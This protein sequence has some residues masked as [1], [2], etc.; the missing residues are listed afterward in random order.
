[1]ATASDTVALGPSWTRRTVCTFKGQSDTHINTGEDYDTCTLAELFTM[2]PG[3]APKGAGPAFIPSTYADYDARNH[4]AQREHGRFV[5]LCGDIDHGDHPLTRV[6]ELVRGFT[7]GAAWL[8]YS[9]AHARPGDMRWRVIIPLDTPLGFADWYDAQHAFFS[10]ME[11]AGVSM[12]KALSRAGQ[13]VYLPNV[14]ETYAKTGEPLRDDFDPLYYQRATSGLNAPGLRIDTGAVCTGMEALRRKRADDD[15]AR[16]E[17]RRQ[18][19]A[20]RARAPQTD[21]API[22]ADFNSANHI[23]TLL[24]LYGYTQCTHSPEDWRSP[25]QTGDTYATRIIGGKWVS[26]SAS[27]TASGMGEKHAAGC[28]GDAYDLFVHYEHGGDHK[29]A[30]RALYKERRNAQ[31]QPDRHT[32][33]GAEDEPEIDPESGQAFTDPPVGEHS[34]DNAP[35]DTL[36]IVHPADWHGETPPDRKWRLQDFIPDLQATLLTGAGAAGKSLTTQQLA[37]CIALGLPFLG[38]PTTQSPALYITCEDDY[39]ELHRRQKA[40]CEALG[41]DLE[42]TRDKLFL[43]SLQGEIG[44]ELATFSH[45]GE[46]KE[47]K[48]YGEILRTCLAHGIKHVTID[49]TAHT[50]A[51]NENDRHQ[52]AAFVNLNNAIARTIGGS[53]LMVG[54]PNK[55]G[56]SYSGSTAWENQV[57]ARLYLEIPRSEEGG[58]IDPDMRVLRN[59]KANY[60]QRGAE[61]RFYW[62]KGAFVT[63][64]DLPQGSDRDVR[65]SAQAGYE[66]NLFLSL[67]DK[68][69]AQKRSTSHKPNA[70]N[71]A[72]R[73]MAGMPA[74]KGVSKEAFAR[75]M[76]RLF[77]LEKIEA[78][79]ELWL[80]SDRHPVFGLGRK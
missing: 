2:E 48:R 80:G 50:F 23:A 43:L 40:I 49:N 9:S 11:Y 5:A 69:S 64:Q 63:E 34:N 35:G 8:I 27:D 58:P 76:E 32:F 14:P 33:Y 74:A 79:A 72:P 20:R 42:A 6:E 31:P 1:M 65:E 22:I 36:A 30:F 26:L 3:D 7:A 77:M 10:F 68:L 51:G 28:Y 37:T 52:V 15:K 60:S 75:A 4:A 18:A 78:E 62:C 25:K 39:E 46:M 66:N 57:R 44:N 38:I 29:S 61:V 12:D 17:L 13:P 56:D 47:A 19:E 53:V 73:I 70:R 45:E 71:F 16:E 59:E 54:H 24:E 55:A 41:V 21:G 67:L